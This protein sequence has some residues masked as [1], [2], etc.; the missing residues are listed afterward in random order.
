MFSGIT[1]FS[2]VGIEYPIYLYNE[3]LGAYAFT[4][5]LIYSPY[6]MGI[7]LAFLSLSVLF[8]LYDLFVKYSVGDE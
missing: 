1:A 8:G 6:M 5:Q 3:T 4:T 2:G 7:N